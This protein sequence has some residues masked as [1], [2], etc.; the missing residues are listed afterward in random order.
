MAKKFSSRVVLNRKAL[1]AFVLAVADGARA[2]A[3]GVIDVAI[4]P[5]APP[6]GQGLVKHG[7]SGAWVDGKKVGG[8]AAKPSSAKL[9]KP[10]ISVLFGYPFPARFQERGT[11][12]QPA[13]PFFS[14]AI[15]DQLRAYEPTVSAYV[16]PVTRK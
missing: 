15:A 9:D 1:D 11:V 2:W 7:D 10:G 14:P 16:K 5:D 8:T 13:R 6:L 12:H 3:D 4:E